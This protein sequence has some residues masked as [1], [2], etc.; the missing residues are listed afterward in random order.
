MKITKTDAR[1]ILKDENL[2][3]G[4]VY[5]SKKPSIQDGPVSELDIEKTIK[6]WEEKGF[7]E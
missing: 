1:K 6:I 3:L 2:S 7:I 5:G 4:I